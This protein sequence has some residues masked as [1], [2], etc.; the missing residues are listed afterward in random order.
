[1]AAIHSITFMRKN[2]EIKMC[3][4]HSG[5]RGRQIS[6]YEASL[7]C[8]VSSR[9]SRA[10]QRN[11]V[12]KQNKTKQKNKTKQNKTNKQKMCSQA[13]FTV[14]LLVWLNSHHIFS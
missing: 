1:M 8:K 5:G 2:Q 6:E 14:I 9:A 11:P 3:S 10:T 7:V 12:S 13:L 4:E